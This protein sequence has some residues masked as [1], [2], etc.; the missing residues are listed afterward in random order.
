MN[1]LMSDLKT[2]LVH[3]V[4]LAATEQTEDVRLYAARMVRRY[5]S[6][7]PDL[8]LQLE[9]C[10]KSSPARGQSPL[11][12]AEAPFSAAPLPVDE[13]SRLSLLK[14]FEIDAKA[15]EPL[16]PP[17]L[18]LTLL[19]LVEERK[20]IRELGAKGLQPT[21]SAILVGPPGVGKTMTARWLASRMR[22]P[23]YALDLT[24]VM[25]SFL[26]RSGGNLRAALDFAKRQS[27]VLLLDEIDAVAKRRS[28]ES[29]V[30]E[31]KR[32]VTVMLQ[33]VEQW[34]SSGLL[35][36]AT[37]HPEL[38]DP[39]LWRRFDLVVNFPMPE[40]HAVWKAVRRFLGED[41]ERF[42]AW[43]DILVKAFT[44]VS[45]SDIE[46]E[47]NRFRRALVL[48]TTAPKDLVAELVRRRAEELDSTSRIDWAVDLARADLLSQRAV[49]EITGVSRDTIR[50]HLKSEAS[51]EGVT[52][53]GKVA[54]V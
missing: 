26:G 21:R 13:D 14:S 49:S 4:R 16:L 28:D 1:G 39:A 37:N 22:L 9:Q 38:I 29:D 27:C 47:I 43:Q 20:R 35:L 2:D 52:K 53:T 7:E 40:P 50:K 23:L 25:S 8:A 24:A 34:P 48:T 30:G 31:L 17:E 5:R 18:R 54:A 42:E 15:E 45:F 10:L 51:E 46:R 3:I 11:R 36:A 32:L 12:R 44:G 41:S 19:Q 33:E 6:V